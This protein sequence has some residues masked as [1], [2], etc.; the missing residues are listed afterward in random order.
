MAR[1][2]TVDI[3]DIQKRFIRAKGCRSFDELTESDRQQLDDVIQYEIELHQ[4][5]MKL[6]AD[7]QA[8]LA[9]RVKEGF[10]AAHAEPQ[11]YSDYKEPKELTGYGWLK[12]IGGVVGVVICIAIK[13]Y[14]LAVICVG[15]VALRYFIHRR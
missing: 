8:E 15:I 1:T 6:E 13:Q 12:V 7:R 9:A 5:Q 2:K 3:H 14:W 10:K 4:K 11:D